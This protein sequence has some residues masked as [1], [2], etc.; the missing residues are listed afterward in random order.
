MVI[1]GHDGSYGFA[2]KAVA[3]KKPLMILATLPRV[4]GPLEKVQL[5]VTVFAMEPILKRL[6]YQV[7]SNAFSN[8]AVI[9][10]VP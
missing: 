4:L 5:P 8:L 1:A 3:V 6:L 10:A 7:Q 2:D 9:T